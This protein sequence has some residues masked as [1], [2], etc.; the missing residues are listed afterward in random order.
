MNDRMIWVI[1]ASSGL[2]RQLVERLATA[3]YSLVLSARHERDLVSLCKHLEILYSVE[4]K[5]FPIDLSN[6]QNSADSELLINEFIK[7]FGKPQMCYMISGVIDDS[8]F[9]LNT[10][11]CLPKLLNVNFIAPALLITDL[12]RRKTT[13]ESLKILVASSVAA[14][15]PRSKNLAYGISKKSLEQF[16]L[17]MLHS[18]CKSD[19]VI[20]IVRFGYMDTNLSYGHKLPFTAA[21]VIRIANQLMD[22]DKKPSGLYY[23]PRFWFLISLV[24]QYMPFWIF[25]KIKS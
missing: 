8:D 14:I 21:S 23:L 25:K 13:T 16:C 12:I 19:L 9:D 6:I 7:Y 18:Q 17:G 20:Q 10:S 1:G 5:S 24:L 3:G 4:A 2:G 22:L 15:R 11:M